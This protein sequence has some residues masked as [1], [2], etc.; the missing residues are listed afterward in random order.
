[1]ALLNTS[2]S[3]TPSRNMV[4]LKLSVWETNPDPATNESTINY[5]LVISKT[6]SWNTSW[7]GWGKKIY[8]SYTIGPKSFTKYIPTY[9]YNGE[10]T[11]GSTIA[12]GKFQVAHNSDGNKSIT[13]S[14][15]FTDNADGNNDGDYYT[16]VMHQR[17][18]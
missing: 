7:T 18:Q 8:A 16:P 3:V 13:I 12:S 4:T 9:N 2:V 14:L 5:K 10:V 17:N 15:S 6:S 11:S 1:M